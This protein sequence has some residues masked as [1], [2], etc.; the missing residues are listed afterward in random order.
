MEVV[1]KVGVGG[2]I[3]KHLSETGKHLLLLVLISCASTIYGCVHMDSCS[4]FLKRA[5]KLQAK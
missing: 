2:W 5:L 1:K 3:R 4:I